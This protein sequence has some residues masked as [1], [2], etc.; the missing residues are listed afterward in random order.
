MRCT[1]IIYIHYNACVQASWLHEQGSHGFLQSLMGKMT[2]AMR[3]RSRVAGYESCCVVRRGHTC[4]NS[5][6][7]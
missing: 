1:A 2:L 6:P 7:G 5:P 3:L 4:I